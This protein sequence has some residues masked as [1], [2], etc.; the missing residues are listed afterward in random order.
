MPK[1]PSCSD[2]IVAAIRATRSS[3]HA[4]NARGGK[5]LSMI[6]SLAKQFYSEQEFRRDLQGLMKND[7]V[8]LVAQVEEARDT[9]SSPLRS[10][11][12]SQIPPG[13]PLN[14]RFWTLDAKG[15]R[16]DE[17]HKAES[18]TRY[19]HPILYVVAD[20]LPTTIAKFVTGNGTTKAEQIMESLQ[21]QK[22][23]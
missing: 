9:S 16:V 6:F 21:K 11:K 15:K 2:F 4:P 19:W 18:Y 14:R 17:P 13:A 7:A 5:A 3:H 1:K 8:L 10:Q 20:G 12:I 23:R 22:K